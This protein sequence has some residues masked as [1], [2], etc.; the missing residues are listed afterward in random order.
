MN[1]ELLELINNLKQ[2]IY[3]SDE[4]Q[5]MKKLEKKIENDS[6]CKKILK[7]KNILIEEYTNSID[8]SGKNSS[9]S[10]KRAQELSSFLCSSLSNDLINQYSK[11]IKKYNELI[12]KINEDIFNKF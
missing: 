8:K 11:S 3:K 2:S 5:N 10:I 7:E 1:I 6:E 12:D 9:L 4:Y